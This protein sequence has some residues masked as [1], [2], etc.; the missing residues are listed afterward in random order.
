VLFVVDSMIGQ[1]AVTTAQAFMEGVGFTGVV[2]TKLDGDAR[3]GAALSVRTVTGQP[4]M[5]ASTGEKLEDFEVFHPDRMASRILDM[6]DVLTLI[7]HAEKAFDRDQAEEMARKLVSEEDFTFDD[8]LAQMAA[9]KQMGSLKKMLGMM[10]GMA[11]IREQLDNLDEREFDRTEAMVHSMT[12]QERAHPKLING[13]R[14]ARIARGSGRTVSDVNDLLDRLAGASKMMKQLRRGG[15][16]PGMPG[17][18]G[19]AGLPGMGGPGRKPKGKGKQRTG[20]RSGNPA[21][22]AEQERA[23]AQRGQQGMDKAIG[24]AFGAGASGPAEPAPEVDPSSVTL[25]PGF[26][27]FLGS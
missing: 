26:E 14:R 16:M 20:G 18:P 27:K 8:F 10:P 23:A 11:G 9:V 1:D 3:G 6:G 15:G 5:F 17:L 7:E 25:P 4:I 22:R 24:S 13:S 21:K 19:M 2:L 12:P